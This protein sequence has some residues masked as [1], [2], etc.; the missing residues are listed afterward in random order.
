M[1][2]DIENLV[3]SSI[4]T[5][6]NNQKNFFEPVEIK[7]GTQIRT[8]FF[9]RQITVNTGFKAT[10]SNNLPTTYPPE[11]AKWGSRQ[12]WVKTSQVGKRGGQSITPRGLDDPERVEGLWSAWFVPAEPQDQATDP[13]TGSVRGVVTRPRR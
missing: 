4:S 1:S 12:Y 7:S 8:G 5:Y 11:Q 6:N 9:S 13:Y 10:K 2:Y 3:K